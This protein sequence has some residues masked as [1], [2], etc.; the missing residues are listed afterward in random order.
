MS[1]IRYEIFDGEA[2]VVGFCSDGGRELTF[3][4]EG[5]GDGFVST[6]DVAARLKDGVASIDSR[7]ISDG[8]HTPMLILKDR[9]IPLPGIKKS[10]SRVTLARCDEDYVRAV[11]LRAHRLTRRV[12]ELEQTI[13]SLCERVY[14]TTVF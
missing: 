12:K 11:S 3:R 5:S 7:L 2:E 14:G 9:R 1:E 4:I 8:E 13:E 6:D 10:G